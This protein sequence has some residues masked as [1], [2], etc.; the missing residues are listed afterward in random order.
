MSSSL[1]RG[2]GWAWRDAMQGG[3]GRA[4]AMAQQQLSSSTVKAALAAGGLG[5]W[6][7]TRQ[8]QGRMCGPSWQLHLLIP[9]SAAPRTPTSHLDTCPTPLAAQP[10]TR[11]C[12]SCRRVPWWAPRPCAARLSCWPSTLPCRS[13]P[14]E[15]W[16]SAGVLGEVGL[17]DWVPFWSG[18][19]PGQ[20]PSFH[21]GK[22]VLGLCPA[23][24]AG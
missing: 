2:V 1:V 18:T 24:H 6:F 5:A 8:Q 13:V 10:S 22:G 3:G 4:P 19:T 23:L 9:H 16:G 7:T 21:V 17:G 15:G 14:G 20:A 12:P 11:A